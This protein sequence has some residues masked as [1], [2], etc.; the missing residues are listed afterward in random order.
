M[1]QLVPWGWGVLEAWGW[2]HTAW[3][4]GSGWG[5]G[6]RLASQQGRAVG[7]LGHCPSG[8]DTA[9]Q[10]PP[11]TAGRLSLHGATV[12]SRPRLLPLPAGLSIRQSLGRVALGSLASLVP[13]PRGAA[14]Q[15]LDY[16]RTPGDPKDRVW[17]RV[18]VFLGGPIGAPPESQTRPG[19]AASRLCR[20]PVE[21]TGGG[22][23]P[24][25]HPGGWP[26]GSS[27]R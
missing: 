17:P 2:G 24:S 11:K 4:M 9:V 3:P 26:G 10:S 19:L 6:L 27:R 21:W 5:A 15:G 16:L 7:G 23:C 22:Q 1:Q 8:A 25:L 18:A 12:I 13:Q 20:R 14:H